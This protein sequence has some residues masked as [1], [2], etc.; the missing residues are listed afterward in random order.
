MKKTILLILIITSTVTAQFTQ[1]R[2]LR[3]NSENI[4]QFEDAVA[5]KTKIFN[6]Q[7]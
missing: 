2:V 1:T 3:V 7:D 4:L 5:K 6:G